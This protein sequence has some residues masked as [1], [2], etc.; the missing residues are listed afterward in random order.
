MIGENPP[1]LTLAAL[2]YKGSCESFSL[3]QWLQARSATSAAV[4][5]QLP[6]SKGFD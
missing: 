2:L 4:A 1:L 3:P 6:L 5:L